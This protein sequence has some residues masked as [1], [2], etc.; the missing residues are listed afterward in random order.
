[1]NLGREWASKLQHLSRGNITNR[2]ANFIKRWPINPKIAVFGAPN[3]FIDEI[4]MR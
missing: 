3:T 2:H 1:M 4:S